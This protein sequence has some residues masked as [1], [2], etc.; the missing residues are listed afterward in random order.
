MADDQYPAARRGPAID[1]G[2]DEQVVIERTG[3]GWQQ[4]RDLIDAW[5]G[6]RDG[7]TAVARWLEQEHG[8]DGWWAQQLT[9]GW[10]RLSG[11]RLPNQLADGTFT[12]NRSATIEVDAEVLRAHLLDADLRAALFPGEAPELRSR[13]TS[14]NV[15]LGVGEGVAELALRPKPDGRVTVTVQH[16]KQIGRAHV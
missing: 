10:E 6:H 3:R 11:R 7:H 15:R 2:A 5:P 12:A 4:W 13:P 9:V 1:P 16:H 8:V 14:K